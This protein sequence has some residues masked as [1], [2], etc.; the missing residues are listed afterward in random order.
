MVQAPIRGMFL[1]GRTAF[2][3]AAAAAVPYLLKTNRKFAQTVGDK[4]IQAGETLKKSGT[5][6]KEDHASASA[7]TPG[8]TPEP[9]V[10]TTAQA[11]QPKSKAAPKK[12]KTATKRSA[13]SKPK[14]TPKSPPRR[15]SGPPAG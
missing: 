14:T 8:P 2:L 6:S 1:L 5:A 13:T 11:S 3:I 10:K 12:P 9:E 7:S 15:R 4:L